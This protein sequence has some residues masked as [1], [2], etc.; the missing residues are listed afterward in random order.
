MVNL[1][2]I[3]AMRYAFLIFILCT[4]YRAKAQLKQPQGNIVLVVHGGAG[5]ILNTKAD[6]KP[7][8]V[9]WKKIQNL[10]Q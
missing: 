5:T 6:K 10:E 1:P 3:T 4:S 7:I 9:L 2:Q 8:P